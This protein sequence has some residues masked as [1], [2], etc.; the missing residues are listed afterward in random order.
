MAKKNRSTV[1]LSLPP[2]I[3]PRPAQVDQGTVLE[4]KLGQIHIDD[5]NDRLV[6]NDAAIAELAESMAKRGLLEPIVVGVVG[7][8]H[9]ARGAEKYTLVAGHRRFA[10]AKLLKWD[11]IRAVVRVYQDDDTLQL[12]RATENVHR[13]ELNPVEEAYAVGGMIDAAMDQAA[14]A[15]ADEALSSGSL[16]IEDA[17][18]VRHQAQVR[19]RAIEIVAGK[20]GKSVTWVNDRAYLSR[21]SGKARQLVLDGRLP[22]TYAREICKV[23]DPDRRDELARDWAAGPELGALPGDFDDLK[24]EVGRVLYSLAQVPWNKSVPFAGAPACDACPHNSVNQPRLFD[25][26]APQDVG[27]QRRYQGQFKRSTNF[28][29]PAAGVCTHEACFKE[30]SA[31]TNRQLAAKSRTIARR[32]KELPKAD[33]PAITAK[34]LQEAAP[35]LKVDVPRFLDPNKLVASVKDEMT[36]KPDNKSSSGGPAQVKAKEKS[37]AEI[38]KE[39]AEDELFDALEK[40]QEKLEDEILKVISKDPMAKV[41]LAVVHQSTLWRQICCS[42]WQRRYDGKSAATAANKPGV[43]QLINLL[44]NPSPAHLKAAGESLKAEH[45]S[46]YSFIYAATDVVDRLAKAM[47]LTVPPRPTLEQFLP[48]DVDDKKGKGNAKVKRHVDEADLDAVDDAG[49]NQPVNKKARKKG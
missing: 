8:E 46:D 31:T 17:S 34:H 20:L 21:L 42:K 15:A 49:D 40:R 11:E 22:L 36:K 4:V 10:A 47:G 29:E 14:Q 23:A 18:D 1:R 9:G 6:H 35:S 39:K 25:H 41:A 5:R 3:E 32:I 12:D 19:K 13:L 37:A 48:K 26:V 30:K 43:Q 28:K 44:A 33:R 45:L 2:V 27:D 16:K 24:F 38:A 7:D